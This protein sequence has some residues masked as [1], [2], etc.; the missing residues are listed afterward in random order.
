MNRNIRKHIEELSST[1]DKIR[2][3]ALQSML[4]A[5][6]SKVDWVYEVWGLLLES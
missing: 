2:M 1:D 6:E 4:K 3:E 5:T